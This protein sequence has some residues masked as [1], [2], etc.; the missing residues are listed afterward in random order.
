MIDPIVEQDLIVEY[1]SSIVPQSVVEGYP[2]QTPVPYTGGRLDPYYAIDFGAPISSALGRSI[3]G[4]QKQPLTM[5]VTIS[6]VADTQRLARELAGVTVKTMTGYQP[7]A[8]ST[9]L[10]PLG[11]GSYTLSTSSTGPTIYA[12]ENSFTFV[13]NQS[14]EPS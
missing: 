12:V 2:E 5:R 6:A 14:P 11:G 9:V 10:R 7:N 3:V 4:E 1:F 8:N 13:I